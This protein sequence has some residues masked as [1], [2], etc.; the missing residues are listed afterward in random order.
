MLDFASDELLVRRP[1]K[2][3]Y[4]V[5][6]RAFLDAN[7]FECEMQEIFGKLWLYLGHE[8]EIPQPGDFIVRRTAGRPLLFVRGSDGQVKALLNS[9]THNGA[10]VCREQAG[11]R[12]HFAC[13]YH[14]WVFDNDGNLLDVPGEA[15]F[16]PHFR[17]NDHGLFPAPSIASYAGFVFVSFSKRTDLVEYLAGAA[18]YLDLLWKGSEGGI[19]VLP[20]TH[21]YASRSNWKMQMLNASDGSHF[22]PTHAT[23]LQF[24]KESGTA[25][26]PLREFQEMPLGNGH[27]VYEY[28]APWGRPHGKPDPAW[29]ENIKAEVEASRSA[30]IDR[31]GP[32]LGDRLA[33]KN[34]NLSI[35][36]N[37][38]INDIV[39]TTI[40]VLEPIA[41]DYVEA[42][43]YQIAPLGDSATLAALRTN[44][45]LTFLGP[46]GFATPDDIE[47]MEA[48]QRGFATYREAPWINYSKGLADQRSRNYIEPGDSDL[49]SRVFF[50][51]WSSALGIGEA[52]MTNVH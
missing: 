34:R 29:D 9:C 39:G 52:G 18:D 46:G 38:I 5:N 36:P 22:M 21:L 47:C 4:H 2:F 43:A 24:I 20:G 7:L 26:E 17:K 14:G 45:F 3:N 8:T 27:T 51:A 6:K 31:L 23:Y 12:K 15:A 49:L 1:E 33:R 25:L 10:T 41:P 40:R 35:F 30:L 37:L 44:H 11:N 32:E 42:S 28:E 13:A 16:G 48:S 50:D 19:R